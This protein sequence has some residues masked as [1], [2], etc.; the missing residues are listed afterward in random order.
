MHR[1]G[2]SRC[3]QGSQRWRARGRWARRDNADQ[4]IRLRG[5]LTSRGGARGALAPLRDR[6]RVSRN[7]ARSQS[8]RGPSVSPR[9]AAPRRPVVVVAPVDEAALCWPSP[10]FRARVARSRCPPPFNRGHSVARM[11]AA[12][13]AAPR[14]E[15][16]PRDPLR[17]LRPAGRPRGG[18]GAHP[19]PQRLPQRP[20]DQPAARYGARPLRFRADCADVPYILR[21]YF[22]CRNRLPFV[23]ARIDDRARRR[24]A[25]PT[26]RA[27][28]GAAALDGS[29]A[30]PRALF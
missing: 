23:D 8:P 5:N 3:L 14:V 18:G 10:R 11:A 27:A 20:R 30:T 24:P 17:A 9:A 21:A 26:R 16:L 7:R 4:G 1:A 22:A 6:A 15:R 29:S 19:P 28:D 25:V 13:P 12:W 2:A